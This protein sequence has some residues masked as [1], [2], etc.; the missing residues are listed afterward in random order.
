MTPSGVPPSLSHRLTDNI[1]I[2]IPPAL[3]S[4]QKDQ[5]RKWQARILCTVYSDSY[6]GA[7][8]SFNISLLSYVLYEIETW[9][10][11]TQNGTIWNSVYL[12]HKTD[13]LHSKESITFI[14]SF[15]LTP[16]WPK[17]WK[18]ERSYF[19]GKA[20]YWILEDFLN[21]REP[22]LTWSQQK[23]LQP[24]TSHKKT[25]N[26]THFSYQACVKGVFYAKS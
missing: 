6:A 18:S 1:K 2:I 26:F 22:H 24:R 13:P 7:N 9:N 25:F 14:I 23:P 17:R 8:G 21:S 5:M 10:Y 19:I 20:R 12:N 3:E 16:F 4:I 15:P 11:C